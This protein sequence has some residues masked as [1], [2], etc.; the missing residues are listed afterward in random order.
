MI[1]ELKRVMI[2]GMGSITPLVNTIEEFWENIV[3]GMSGV[4]MITKFNTTHLKQSL[5]PK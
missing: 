2:T 4:G 5:P 1:K 3:A